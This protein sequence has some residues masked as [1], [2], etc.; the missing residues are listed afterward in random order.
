MGTSY[1]NPWHNPSNSMYGP[2]RYYTHAEP[3]EY[4]GFLIYE[5]ITGSCW[6]VVKDGACVT[7]RAGPNGA[8]RSIDE[9]TP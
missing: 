3:K 9:Q 1:K 2:E 8:R 4:K 6:D 5:R 7:Q